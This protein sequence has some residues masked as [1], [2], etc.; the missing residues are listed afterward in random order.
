[1]KMRTQVFFVILFTCAFV[2]FTKINKG[3]DVLLGLWWNHEKDAHI[4]IYKCGDQ[5]CGKI[6]WLEEPN[7][8]GAPKKD[9]NNPEETLQKRPIM[10]LDILNGFEFKEEGSWVDGKIYNPR[11]GKTYS[12]YLKLLE[13][14]KLKVRGFV[15]ISLI[16]KTQYWER[17]N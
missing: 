4:E 6:V 8:D 9:K 13:D 1:M 16:G 2:S 3:P 12:C 15:G 10:G 11:D 5:F 7:E 14:G 17:V